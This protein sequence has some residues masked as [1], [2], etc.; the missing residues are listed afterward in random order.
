M[1]TCGKCVAASG[2]L[3]RPMPSHAHMSL[4]LVRSELAARPPRSAEAVRRHGERVAAMLKAAGVEAQWVECRTSWVSAGPV[5]VIQAPDDRTA[6]AAAGPIR[7]TNASTQGGA[8][9][10]RPAPGPPLAR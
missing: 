10:P 9:T 1:S 6:Q 5:D 7:P 8:P 2:R 3:A 4:Y